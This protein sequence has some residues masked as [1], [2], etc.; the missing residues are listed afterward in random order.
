MIETCSCMSLSTQGDL[1]SPTNGW[2]DSANRSTE[3]SAP[4][5]ERISKNSEDRVAEQVDTL[6]HHAV[7]GQMWDKAVTYLRRAGQRDGARSANRQA[8]RYFEQALDA[9]NHLPD[10]RSA[11]ELGINIRLDL[12]NVLVPQGEFSSKYLTAEDGNI[13]DLRDKALA[14]MVIR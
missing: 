12:R 5:E 1:Y 13:P 7:R 6:S 14:R 10:H 9:L 4:A 8:A 2:P 3:R 11:W